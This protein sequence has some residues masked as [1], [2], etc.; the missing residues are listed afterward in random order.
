MDSTGD[1][2][3][4]SN[5]DY[6][7]YKRSKIINLISASC[8]EDDLFLKSK[9]IYDDNKIKFIYDHVLKVTHE[10]Q[11][12]LLRNGLILNYDYLLIASGGSPIMLPWKG[13]DLEGVNTLYRLDDAK[14]V[15]K[16]VFNAKRVVVIGGGSI[17]MKAL[18]NFKKIGLDI[19]IIEKAW[20]FRYY[21]FIIQN[22]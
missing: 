13:V 3:I 12:I 4:I 22:S 2:S 11:Q 21:S 19:S 9:K 20:I 10:K 16:Q 14:K 5:E 17:A 8:S 1:I 18:S 6:Q 7:F 15:V